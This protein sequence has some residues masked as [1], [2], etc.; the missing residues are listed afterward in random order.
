MQPA[1]QHI[2]LFVRNIKTMSRF[3]TQQLQF[4]LERDYV[5]ERGQMKD[6]FGIDAPC[7]IQ[8]LSLRGFGVELFQFRG[9]RLIERRARTAGLNHWTLLV[10]DKYL[11]CEKLRK[12]KISVIQ[13]IK[14]HGHTFF[15]KDPEG[16]LIEVKSFE[17]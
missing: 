4:T 11:F 7:R 5:A 9:T 16:N 10:E 15:I 8:Y 1:C 14:S 12:K 6:I 17:V 13:I 3:Y 2:A